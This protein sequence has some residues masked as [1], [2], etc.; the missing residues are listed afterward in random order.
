MVFLKIATSEPIASTEQAWLWSLE[1]CIENF[2]NNLIKQNHKL[3]SDSVLQQSTT[4]SK[5]KSP[6][7]CI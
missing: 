6:E 1:I 2:F 7:S 5:V 3:D 4:V